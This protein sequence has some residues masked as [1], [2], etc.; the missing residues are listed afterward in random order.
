MRAMYEQAS[1]NIDY[2]CD[3]W[4]VDLCKNDPEMRIISSGGFT[5][6][7]DGMHEYIVE[8]FENYLY[9]YFKKYFELFAIEAYDLAD[10]YD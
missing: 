9:A 8:G 3:L 4:I 5:A 2:K 10:Y 6:N 7:E 1:N